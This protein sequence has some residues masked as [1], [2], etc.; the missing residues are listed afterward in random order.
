MFFKRC[1]IIAGGVAIEDIDNFNRLS[2]MLHALTSEEEQL[3]IASEG[4]GS[5]DDKYAN[6]TADT[7]KSYRLENHEQSGIVSA[8][9]RV[10]FKPLIGL[11]NQRKINSFKVLPYSNRT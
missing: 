4:F 8:A 6:A 7:R 5:F 2:I 3:G 10:M 9:G 1:R 11:F